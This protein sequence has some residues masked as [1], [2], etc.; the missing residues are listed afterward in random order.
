MRNN[1]NECRK[2]LKVKNEIRVPNG[3]N[4]D[5]AYHTHLLDLLATL[6]EVRKGECNLAAS[7]SRGA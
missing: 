1:K 6:G 5:E 7:L 4:H 2:K 3:P